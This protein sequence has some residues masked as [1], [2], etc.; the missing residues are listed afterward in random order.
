MAK[1]VSAAVKHLD[2]GLGF[3]SSPSTSEVGRG[4]PSPSQGVDF[5]VFWLGSVRCQ[6]TGGVLD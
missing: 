3:S 4:L 6:L 5:S 1:K 2:S